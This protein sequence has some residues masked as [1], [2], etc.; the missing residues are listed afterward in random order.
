M[1]L[2]RNVMRALRGH[3]IDAGISDE[4]PQIVQLWLLRLLVPLAGHR[5]FINQRGFSND[6]LAECLGLGH[7]V[8]PVDH[9][10]DAKS[11]RMALRKLHQKVEREFIHA[12][13]PTCLTKNV[14]RLS[15]LVGLSGTD[16]RILEFAVVLHNER[17]LDDTADW[18]GQLSSAKVFHALSIILNIPEHQIR[19]ALSANGIL[20]KSGL[21][22]VSR[23]GSSTLRGKLDL[24]S[25]N[26]ADNIFSSESDPVCL[27]RDT[28]AQGQPAELCIDDYEHIAE[29]LDILRPYL[30]KSITTGRKGVNVFFHGAPGTGKSQLAKALA[31]EMG[32]ELFEVASEDGDGDPVSGERRL[33]AYSAAQSFFATRRAVIVFDEVED[34]FNDGNDEIGRKSTAQT[35]KAWINRTLEENRVPTLWLSNSIHGVDS[36]FIRR[37]DMV[38]EIPV[39]PKKQRERILAAACADIVDAATLARIAESESLA[40]AVV[41]RAASVVRSINDEMNP[42]HAAS[43]LELLISNTLEA[44]GHKPI[45]EL[46]VCG[47]PSIYDPSFVHADADLSQLAKGLLLSKSGRICLFGPPGTGKTAYGRWIA[48]QLNIPLLVK[49]ASDLMSMWVGGNEKNIANAFKQATREGALLLIDEVDSFLQDR[50]SARSGWEVSLVNEML[51][52]MEAFPGVFIASTN[53]MDGLDQASLRRFDIKVQF[54]FLKPDQAFELLRRYCVQ[55]FISAPS[56]AHRAQLAK[57]C[58]LT[59]GD[60]AAVIR[61]HRFRPISGVDEFIGALTAEC[62]LKGGRNTPIGFLQ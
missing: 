58:R 23:S 59:P 55:L 12:A 37:F 36:A 48:E 20:S 46:N 57:L 31:N 24:L 3:T 25:D 7:W 22:S 8:D 56:P 62:T 13:L 10:F 28:V 54:D 21:V 9:D 33:R 11:V 52:Q 50:R 41:T 34:V 6:Q 49:R 43:A 29:A 53:L 26:F 35:R 44:Q 42:G 5:E 32:C 4:V 18:L 27:L 51:T 47:L 61:Q 45:R 39:P 40:P 38:I 16:A 1:K 2:N 15:T 30:Q 19:I 14:A 17:I 60:Y